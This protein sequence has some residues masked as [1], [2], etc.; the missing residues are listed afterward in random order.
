VGGRLLAAGSPTVLGDFYP[1][2]TPVG[3]QDDKALVVQAVSAGF[4]HSG[5]LTVRGR[6]GGVPLGRAGPCATQHV[7]LSPLAHGLSLC[8]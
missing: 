1:T 8:A 2:F 3:P 4:L 7:R 5:A 6:C